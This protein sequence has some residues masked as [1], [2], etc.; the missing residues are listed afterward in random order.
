MYW[1]CG[2]AGVVGVR[3]SSLGSRVQLE[4]SSVSVGR[5]DVFCSLPA[6]WVN[7]NFFPEAWFCWH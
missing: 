6:G 4:L 2:G 1:G 3:I 5:H 7:L